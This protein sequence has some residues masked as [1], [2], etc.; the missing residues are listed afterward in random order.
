MYPPGDLELVQIVDAALADATLRSG[1]HLV[2]H[3]GCTPCCHGVFAISSLDAARLQAGLASL[4]QTDPD[5]ASRIRRRVS[6]TVMKLAPDFPGD[7]TTGH[8]AIDEVSQERFEDFANDEPCP[9]L[10]PA[11]GTCDLYSH[12][13]MT[14]RVFGPPVRSAGGLGICELCFQDA[15]EPEISAAEIHLPDPSIEADLTRP[16]GDW[17]TII[18]FALQRK[19]DRA[20]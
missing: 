1:P 9:V 7:P 11:T 5:R 19:N 6:A 10:D 16:L 18:A 14:C 20:L 4:S 17:T 2:C 3:P 12:R 8:L 15:T 13:P